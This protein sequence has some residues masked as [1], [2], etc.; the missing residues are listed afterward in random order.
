MDNVEMNSLISNIISSAIKSE[1]DAI[2][3][4]NSSIVTLESNSEENADKII[5]VL[6]DI[7]DEEYVH[8]GQLESCLSLL[9]SNPAEQIE[10]GS[11]EGFEQ[12]EL[13]ED[14]EE[15]ELELEEDLDDDISRDELN[16]KIS[17]LILK[18]L[19]SVEITPETLEDWD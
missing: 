6:E 14:D 3:I 8:V 4:Y 1:W 2:D 9:R 18:K 15:L 19:P 7:R 10:D 16:K 13:P 5:K 11:E 17:N 12:L